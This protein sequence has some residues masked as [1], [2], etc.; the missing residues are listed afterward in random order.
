MRKALLVVIG[1]LTVAIAA[2]Y[3][4]S[5]QG[6][7]IAK[8]ETREVH[9]F[10]AI[11][12][13]GAGRLIVEQG[14]TESL[15]VTADDDVVPLLETEVNDGTLVI[16]VKRHNIFNFGFRT[17]T[18]IEFK[19]VVKDLTRV[20][21]TG[22]GDAD[23]IELETKKLDVTMTGVGSLTAG[24][25]ADHLTVTLSGSGSFQGEDF[26]TKTATVTCSGVG[27]AVVNVSEKLDASVSGVGSIEYIGTPQVTEKVSGIG[28][29]KKR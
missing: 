3:F 18:P 27:N 2:W 10:S 20:A 23:L 15:T 7:G 25:S 8:T 4:T 12:F 21:L 6:S 9:G 26:A 19:V 13:T 1:L 24:G 16:G 29:V 5:A 17:R 22:A 11:S 14:P 28:K